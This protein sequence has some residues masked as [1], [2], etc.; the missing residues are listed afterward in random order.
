MHKPYIATVSS[1]L[2]SPDLFVSTWALSETNKAT[3]DMVKEYNYFN[4]TSLLLA[5]QKAS[6]TFKYAQ[7]IEALPTQYTA[8]YQAETEYLPN[9]YYLFA[10]KK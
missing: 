10:T 6:D 9:N 4:S 2:Q 3:Q 8:T 5:Y 7:D 1:Q